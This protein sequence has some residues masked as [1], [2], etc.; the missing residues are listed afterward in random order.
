[1]SRQRSVL[2]LIVVP[3]VVSLAVTVLVLTL[4]DRQQGPEYIMLPTHSG[5][6]QIPPRETRPP[7]EASAGEEAAPAETGGEE[8]LVPTIEP[9]CENPVHTVVGGDTL[10]VI[11]EQ[12]GVTVEEITAMNLYVDRDFNPNILS[13]DQELVIPVCGI[14]TPTPTGEPT[15]TTVPTR[16]IPTPLATGTEPP[17]G[18]VV[19]EIA[20]VLSPGEI[21]AEAVEVI[22]RGSSVARLDGWT[23]YNERSDEEFEF[24][25]L[26]LFPQGAITIHTGVGEDSAI[27]VYWGRD[28]PVWQPGDTV[29]LY[30]TDGELQF[31]FDIPEE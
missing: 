25:P 8:E 9:G 19:V 3:A 31:E 18:Q 5:T 6:A 22:N 15:N 24:P 10:S 7:A 16:N 30:N 26:N 11:A 27:D 12:Y 28:A 4:W 1:M 13:I 17:P 20:R 21:T 14:P 23:L 2:V 29:Q